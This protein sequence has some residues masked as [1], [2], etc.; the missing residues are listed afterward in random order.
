MVCLGV[1]TAVIV[2]A[3]A[4][5]GSATT[6]AKPMDVYAIAPSE[7]DVRSLLGDS[8]WTETP[9]SF[10]VLPLDFATRNPLEQYSV[11]VRFIRL[12]TA[13]ELFA[14]YTLYDK[15]SSATTAM[16][17]F[18]LAFGTSPTSPKVGDQVLY[19]GLG[20]SGGAPLIYRTFVRVGQVVVTIVWARKDR[21]ASSQQLLDQL[22]KNAK[23]F[24]AGVKNLGKVHSNLKPV[25]AK[26]LPPPN[27]D[28]TLLGSAMMPIGAFPPMTDAAL[29]DTVAAILRQGGVNSFAY[30]DFALNND[31]HMEVQT[32]LLAFGA[33]ADAL[34]YAS[35]FGGALGAPDPSGLYSQYVPT[36]GSPDAGKY[37]YIFSTGVYGIYM[38]CK[39]SVDGEAASREC[40]SPMKRTATAWS[41]ALQGI[42]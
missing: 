7:S 10:E 25:D 21:M 39:S 36:S 29:P 26:Q 31:T 24:T 33:P 14:R 9:P 16:S 17:D 37:H 34:G 15:S 38:I 41:L 27:L 42:G 1:V 8:N 28:L 30:G 35:G 32:A 18:Q 2:S 19:Y 13:E 4:A 20:G 23:K 6:R 12:G 22:A 40:E 11:S 5:P 3:C